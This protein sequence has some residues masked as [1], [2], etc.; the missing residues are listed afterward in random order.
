MKLLL[1]MDHD[2]IRSFVECSVDLQKILATRRQLA[3]VSWRVSH[4][5]FCTLQ[6]QV[7]EV[8]VLT[9]TVESWPS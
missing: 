2:V 8:S 5:I 1:M 3:T 9:H 7:R 6:W 4:Q